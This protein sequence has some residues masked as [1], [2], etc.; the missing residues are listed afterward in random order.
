MQKMNENKT[1]YR[2]IVKKQKGITL[3]ALVITIIVLLILAS[4]TIGAI[5]GDNGILQNAGKAKVETRAA[6]V[7]ERKNLW[8]IEKTG[9]KYLE[10]DSTQELEDL[11]NDLEKEKLITAEERKEIEEKGHV[12]IGSKDISFSDGLTEETYTITNSLDE[13]SFNKVITEG[14]IATEKPGYTSYKIEGISND[15]EGEYKDTGSVSGNSGNLEII[16]NISDATFRY[17][18]TDFM[19]GDETFYCKINIDGKEYYKILKIEQGDVIT[20]EE[21]FAGIVYEGSTWTD[22]INE[23]YTNGKAKKADTTNGAARISFTYIGRG[24]EVISRVGETGWLQ[25]LSP[26]DTITQYRDTGEGPEYDI[27]NANIVEG[28]FDD[29]EYGTHAIQITQAKVSNIASRYPNFYIDAIKIY[30]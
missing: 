13:I 25:I 4:V 10:E 6:T 24:C 26:N 17:N 7:E 20:Y 5:S 21:D 18:L 1:K 30:K 15:K 9:D 27:F 16:G 29:L 12:I 28:I 2:K 14:D 22:D 23:N 3:I 11:L 19:Q 8:K